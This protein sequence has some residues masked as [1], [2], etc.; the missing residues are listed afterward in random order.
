MPIAL[1]GTVQSGTSSGGSGDV[2]LTFDVA[3]QEHDV[4][5]VG[6]GA[7]SLT[8]IGPDTIGY[9][10]IKTSPSN[11]GL[12]A[13]YKVLGATPD[14]SVLC[15]K[16]GNSADGVAYCSYVLRGVDA[17][18]LDALGV[19]ANGAA[20]PIT[21]DPITTATDGAWVMQFTALS[22]VNLITAAPPGYT[23]TVF[24]QGVDTN[25]YN[26]G[27]A[28]KLVAA[29]GVEAAGTWSTENDTASTPWAAL[30][31]AIKPLAVASSPA[32]HGAGVLTAHHNGSQITWHIP[33]TTDLTAYPSYQI[34]Y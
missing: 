4:V 27:A 28:T 6:G 16:D 34:G 5:I 21:P 20:E 14:P 8:A 7:A 32:H 18:V 10:A 19:A 31:I 24:T 15:K 3:P 26:L 23:N 12:G 11:I 25:R 30:T 33:S 22:G 9:T 13:W 17:A 2:T 1:V 29:A